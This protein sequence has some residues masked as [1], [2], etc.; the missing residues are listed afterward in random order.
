MLTNDSGRTLKDFSM[1]FL[2]PF[3][4]HADTAYRL[5]FTGRVFNDWERFIWLAESCASD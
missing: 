2:F 4:L 1:D 5:P 3:I